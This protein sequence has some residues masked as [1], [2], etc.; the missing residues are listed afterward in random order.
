MSA[1][2]SAAI[3]WSA[4]AAL[5]IAALPLLFRNM[6]AIPAHVPLDP[7]E[8]WNAAHALAVLAGHGLYPPPQSLMV[9]NYPP[10]SFYLIAGIARHGGDA[11][12]MGR[13]L[14][15]LAFL[16]SGACIALALLRM[17]CEPRN[18]LLAVLFFAAVLL[19]T[20]DYVGM[21]DPQLLGHALQLAALL[22]LLR[23]RIVASAALFAVSLFI[24]HNLLA[25]PLGAGLWL[26]EQ[27]RRTGFEFILWGLA[28]T[29]AGLVV[30]QL[31][32]GTSLLGQLASPRLSSLAN[33]E[34]AAKHLWWMILPAAALVGLW[35][36]RYGLFCAHY[37]AA[38]LV[39]GLIFAAGDGVDANVF[40]D[41]AIALSLGAGLAAERGRWPF[42]SAAAAVPLLIFLA[43]TFQ[44]NDFSFTRA[45]RAQSARDIAFLKGRLGPS[46]CD[47]LSLC[48][49]AGKSAQVDVFNIG[50][51]IKSGARDPSALARM[52]NQKRF[53][54]L[55][56]LD[57]AALGPLV[58]QAIET[59]YRADH[60]DD[61]G[62]FWVTQIKP[63]P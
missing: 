50:E 36:D 32:F 23:E 21:D 1:R 35:P 44:D 62:T 25:M 2:L 9:N 56:L 28:F 61:N 55:Q 47:Q 13:W 6:L 48:L 30:F 24:K 14:A 17:D 12:I 60:T 11:I 5:A 19:I 7:N 18:A 57:D 49:W 63:S 59:N 53:A 52:I 54:T 3:V 37:A 45:F 42:L 40:F 46:L 43:V 38:A 34:A 51:Q 20:S 15:L 22:L 31:G 27:D 4:I 29:L 33:L 58:R 41:L 39:L 10:L 16:A 8:G 26:L